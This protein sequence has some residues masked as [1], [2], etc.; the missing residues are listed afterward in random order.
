VR[1]ALRILAEEPR[2]CALKSLVLLE[3][4][5]SSSARHFSTSSL[6]WGWLSYRASPVL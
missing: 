6:I 4:A 5:E 1:D 2:S 3:L